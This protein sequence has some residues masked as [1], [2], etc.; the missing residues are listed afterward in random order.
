[1]QMITAII[2]PD[3]LDDVREELVAAGITRITTS[4]VTGHGQ[5][6]EI[7]GERLY[8]GQKVIP[9]LLPKVRLDIA[10]N[11]E[12]VEVAIEAI[13]RSAKHG[14]GEIGDGKIFVTELKECI[15][16]RTEER[17]GQAI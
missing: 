11:D 1:M 14:E 7:S 9:N 3:K 16:I 2:K 8:R 17:G 13:L 6:Q 5:H 10:C 4:R 15:R 12:Y